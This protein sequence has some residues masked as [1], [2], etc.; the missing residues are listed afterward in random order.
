MQCHCIPKATVFGR[1]K[2]LALNARSIFIA[3]A[4]LLLGAQEA[5]AKDVPFDWKAAYVQPQDARVTVAQDVW[6]LLAEISDRE[7]DRVIIHN[8]DIVLLMNLLQADGRYDASE[9]DLMEE[10]ITEESRIISIWPTGNTE[11]RTSLPAINVFRPYFRPILE[12]GIVRLKFLARTEAR[13]RK[14]MLLRRTR[15]PTRQRRLIESLALFSWR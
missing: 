3:A 5:V 6:N 10:M 13:S 1:L 2:G 7:P 4:I 12:E 15:R 14:F 9:I 8:A 11:R